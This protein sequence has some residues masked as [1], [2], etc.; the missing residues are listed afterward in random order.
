[1]AVGSGLPGEVI[2]GVTFRGLQKAALFFLFCF[3]VIRGHIA[4]SHV[5]LHYQMVLSSKIVGL[6]I[7][8][9][10]YLTVS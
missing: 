9:Q 5:P 10:T 6:P 3:I 2:R 8:D 1:M 4:V 7:T